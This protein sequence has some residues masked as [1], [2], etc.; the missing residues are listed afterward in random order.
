MR[1]KCLGKVAKHEFDIFIRLGIAQNKTQ[2]EP[3]SLSRPE[4]DL[5]IIPNIFLE[6]VRVPC[7]YYGAVC[8]KTQYPRLQILFTA[9]VIEHVCLKR[10]RWGVYAA[11]LQT[12]RAKECHTLSFTNEMRQR[13][14]PSGGTAVS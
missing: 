7:V 3:L 11:V 6:A 5:N 14:P 4:I 2:V 12:R 10:S 1:N 9:G 8:R 13:M